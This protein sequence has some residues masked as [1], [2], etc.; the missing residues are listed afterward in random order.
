MPPCEGA[1]PGRSAPATSEGWLEAP[2]SR[3][4]F[5]S[6]RVAQSI[7]QRQGIAHKAGD[8]SELR[9]TRIPGTRRKSLSRPFLPNGSPG[10]VVSVMPHNPTPRYHPVP[11]GIP[12]NDEEF[13]A[14]AMECTRTCICIS[15][16]RL[17]NF[18]GVGHFSGIASTCTST[19]SWLNGL[20]C[21]LHKHMVILHADQVSPVDNPFHG[22]PSV[23][24]THALC[25]TGDCKRYTV[26]A[27][28]AHTYRREP[29][30]V[31][32]LPLLSEPRDGTTAQHA[33]SNIS[34]QHATGANFPST[35]ANQCPWAQRRRKPS[36]RFEQIQ[37]H[38]T[39]QRK[40]HEARDG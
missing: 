11:W 5:Y 30:P 20:M 25:D 23:R 27:L 40:H 32:L 6:C 17:S 4:H 1:A 14:L 22:R 18:L 13:R 24:T 2:Q 3:T 29:T 38:H 31:H 26:A 19:S 28:L 7:T 36:E 16:R 10:G 12:S 9:V 39:H 34:S 8:P 21:I 35:L 37:H 15:R 33:L